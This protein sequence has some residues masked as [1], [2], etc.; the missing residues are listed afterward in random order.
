MNIIHNLNLTPYSQK[1]RREMTPEERK[2]WYNFLKGIPLTVHRQKVIENYIVDFYIAQA[3]IIIELDGSQHYDDKA[4][5]LD[6][7]RNKRLKE[8]GY[9]VKIYEFRYY[10]AIQ[11]SLYGYRKSLR[12]AVVTPHPSCNASHLPLKGKARI[13][14]RYTKRTYQM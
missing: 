9:T 5:R 7:I 12:G 3:K 10:S 14:N 4:A 6:E 11:R 1:L 2:L 8:L 13:E